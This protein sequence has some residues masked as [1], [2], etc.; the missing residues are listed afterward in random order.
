MTSCRICGE[1]EELFHPCKC[2]GSIRFIHEPCLMKWLALSDKTHC[3]LCGHEYSFDEEYVKISTKHC[4]FV[5]LNLV[6]TLVAEGVSLFISFDDESTISRIL[7][8]VIICI[9]SIFF[10]KKLPKSL[11]LISSISLRVALDHLLISSIIASTISIIWI[12]SRLPIIQS[13][14]ILKPLAVGKVVLWEI[15]GDIFHI[16]SLSISVGLFVSSIIWVS[17]QFIK[18]K[19]NTRHLNIYDSVLKETF[20]DIIIVL[21]C[22]LPGISFLK[23]FHILPFS[24]DTPHTIPFEFFYAHFCVPLVLNIPPIPKFLSNIKIPNR[25]IVLFGFLF[26]L[27]LLLIGLP[28][29]TGRLI[30]GSD[31]IVSL[32]VGTLVC[33]AVGQIV[34]RL[35][36]ILESLE[37][38]SFKID[39]PKIKT[40]CSSIG[41]FLIA[42][43]IVGFAFHVSL[44][45]PLKFFNQTTGSTLILPV[46]IIGL[47]LIK[48]AI[49]FISMGYQRT[50][51]QQIINEFETNGILSETFQNS[52]Y[53]LFISLAKKIF[54]HVFFPYFFLVLFEF[55]LSFFDVPNF[56]HILLHSALPLYFVSHLVPLG[57]QFWVKESKKFRKKTKLINYKN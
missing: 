30:C 43:L 6:N 11:T 38:V 44:I 14:Y 56:I 17:K 18:I 2:S 21:C 15:S 57:Q 25:F 54:K 26:T 42:P 45:V 49:A 41:I 32:F 23:F 1:G 5:L 13:I 51:F 20:E 50:R 48:I 31:S 36:C 19:F 39:F 7:K 28:V 29:L 9:F 22:I 12:G 55:C 34:L 24:F 16:L 47:M 46:W 10:Q 53:T 8:M 52:I 4:L 35:L 27:V 37:S 40:L 33:L 3:E